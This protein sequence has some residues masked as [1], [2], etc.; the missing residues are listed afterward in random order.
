MPKKQRLSRVD[1]STIN[2]ARSRRFF[3]TYFTMSISPR[4]VESSKNEPKFACVVSKKIAAHAAD[5]NRIRRLCR[6]A[7][8]SAAGAAHKAQAHIFYAKK[9]SKTATFHDV[10]ADVKSLLSRIK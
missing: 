7:F 3:G 5:R 8:R 9:E 6:E 1:L 4:K 10:T 2:V